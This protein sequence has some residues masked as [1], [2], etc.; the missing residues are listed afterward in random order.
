M[1]QFAWYGCRYFRFCDGSAVVPGLLLGP[2][3][4]RSWQTTDGGA[5]VVAGAIWIAFVAPPGADD[6]GLEYDLLEGLLVLDHLDSARGEN[7]TTPTFVNS[8]P[9]VSV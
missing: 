9:S 7:A 1:R 4:V 5:L 8:L 3:G 2:S 6:D